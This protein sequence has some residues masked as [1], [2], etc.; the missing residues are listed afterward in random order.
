MPNIIAQQRTLIVD[1]PTEAE[2]LESLKLLPSGKSPSS[3][4]FASKAVLILWPIVGKRYTK[5]VLE[6]WRTGNLL[7]FFKDGILFL[8]PKVDI[9]DP[10][11]REESVVPTWL[12]LFGVQ[13]VQASEPTRYLGAAIVADWRGVSN[14]DQILAK[15]TRRAQLFSSSLL[16]FE[17]RVIGLK[18]LVFATLIYPL[19]TMPIKKALKRRVK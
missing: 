14:T 6:F 12:G 15:V 13:L 8:L 11:D 2:I 19:F 3:D 7:L 5:A 17:A 16:S 1:T 9:P 18:H 10:A 4:G